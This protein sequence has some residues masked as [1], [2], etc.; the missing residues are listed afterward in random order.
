MH[1]LKKKNVELDRERERR[2]EKELAVARYI[3]KS[4]LYCAFIWEMH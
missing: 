3:L 1:K 4:M 2:N